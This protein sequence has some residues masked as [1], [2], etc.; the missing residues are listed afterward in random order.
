MEADTHN[1][2][3][4]IPEPPF[5]A[6]PPHGYDDVSLQESAHDWIEHN[7]STAMLVAFGVGVF[8][9]VLMRR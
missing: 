5:E 7:Q 1:Q 8:L 2:T 6:L 4:T 3:E 9:G